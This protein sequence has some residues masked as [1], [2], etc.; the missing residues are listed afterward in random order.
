MFN[1]IDGT[2]R[3]KIDGT[4][5]R[6][7]ACAIGIA[8]LIGVAFATAGV[9]AAD[10]VVENQY[11]IKGS[12]SISVAIHCP[13]GMVLNNTDYSSKDRAVPYGVEVIEAGTAVGVNMGSQTT[14]DQYSKRMKAA[15]GTATNW[16]P[17]SQDVIIKGH[18]VN[19]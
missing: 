6:K 8:A 5:C 7:W 15:S 19:A 1:T 12:D 14:G 2:H 9:A 10:Q 16:S 4:H 3:R 17:F 13:D 18:C 11:T